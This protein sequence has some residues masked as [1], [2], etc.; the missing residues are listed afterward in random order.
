MSRRAAWRWGCLLAVG[1]GLGAALALP[2]GAVGA[3]AQ[4]QVGD[5]GKKSGAE[6]T[7]FYPNQAVVHVGDKVKFSIVGFHTVVFPKKRSSL[8]PL[9]VPGAPNAPKTDP[10]GQPYWWSGITPQLNFNPAVAAPSG[11]TAV[12]GAKTVNSGAPQGRRPTFTV[13]FPK[14]GTYQVRCAVHPNMRGSV[15]VLPED[16]PLKSAAQVR[17]AVKKEKA[18][19]AKAA[20]SLVKTAPAKAGASD[21]IIGPGN[22]RIDVF[23]FFPSTRTVPLNSTVTFR[24]G[25]REE[26]HTAT[27]GPQPFLDAV[28]KAS[29]EG[30]GL[31]I[32]SEGAYPSDP[33]QAG[34]P[35]VT[36]TAHGNGFV[37]S[38]VLSDPGVIKGQP[39]SF[40]FRFSTPGTFQFEC[41]V[42]SDMKGSIV[43]TP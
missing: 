25:G 7:A 17:A 18:A 39:S 22:A 5:F 28:T 31:A 36:P 34:P 6:F 8:P 20:A 14:A 23:G 10:A 38:G 26:I 41:L 13:S 19:D 40:T 24:M 11:G 42:H 35:A 32:G 37:S 43:V 3:T 4:V 2:A 33:P 15:K 29:F 16:S 12:T 27:F 21:I 30:N 1:C 9:V